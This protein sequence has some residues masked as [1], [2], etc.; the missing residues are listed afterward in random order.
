MMDKN[1][2]VYRHIRCDNN[3]VFYVGVGCAAG[4]RRAYSRHARNESWKGIVSKTEWRV[5]VFFEN[6]TLNEAFEKEVFFISLHGRLDK[7]TGTLANRSAGGDGNG[8][9]IHSR[10]LKRSAEARKNISLGQIGRTHP[11]ES[12]EKMRCAKLGIKQQQSHIDNMANAHKKI[13]FDTNTG[14]Y[15]LGFEEASRAK[16][17]SKD[18][19]AHCVRGPLKNRTGIIYA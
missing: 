4:L 19:L 5:E 3:E 8:G 10:G 12:L 13:L 2:Y 11:V 18:Y 9:G 15:Y 7:G 17:L 16:N 14:I 6:I 1:W